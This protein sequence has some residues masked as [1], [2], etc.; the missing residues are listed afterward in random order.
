MSKDQTPLRQLESQSSPFRETLLR[1]SGSIMVLDE[2][3]LSAPPV[4]SG[5]QH[6]AEGITTGTDSSASA[7]NDGHTAYQ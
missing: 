7:R 2:E 4:T 3:L 1:I 6:Q 5:N